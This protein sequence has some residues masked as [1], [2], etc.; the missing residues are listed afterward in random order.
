MT[1]RFSGHDDYLSLFGTWVGAW[2]RSCEPSVGLPWIVRC[3]GRSEKDS[4]PQKSDRI[5]TFLFALGTLEFS[6][7]R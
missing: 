7:L 6:C 4:I 5:A 3:L 1:L 2:D